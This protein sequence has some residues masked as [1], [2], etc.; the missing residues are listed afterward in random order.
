MTLIIPNGV[1]VY[2]ESLTKGHPVANVEGL[3]KLGKEIGEAIFALKDGLQVTDLSE[4]VD[5]GAAAIAVSG[6]ISDDP[7]SA[8]ANI[9]AGL[10]DWFAEQRRSTPSP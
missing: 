5:I 2:I 7:S 6:D 8:G 1:E 4:V 9:A 10:L 3:H